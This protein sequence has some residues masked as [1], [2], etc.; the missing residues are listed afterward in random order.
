MESLSGLKVFEA[1]ATAGAFARA[2][3]DLDLSTSATSKSIARLES[4]L[5]VKLFR[6]TTRKVSLT[7][8]G[9]R[10]L[11]GIKPILRDL[12]A[13]KGEMAGTRDTP[14]G[15][16]TV[17][18]PAAFG[19]MALIPKLAPFQEGFPDVQLELRLE[20]RLVDLVSDNIDVAIRA[21]ALT[22]SATLIAR[23]LFDDQL[24]TCAAPAYLEREGLPRS[25]EDLDRHACLAFRNVG[26]GRVAPWFF[27]QEGSVDR[28]V[29]EGGVTSNDGEGVA[30]AAMA[31]LGIS[32]MPSYMA[33]AAIADGRLVEVL[34][35]LRPP[36]TQFHAL[37]LDRRLMP[38]RLRVFVDYLVDAFSRDA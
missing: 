34:E 19:R 17:S 33:S 10:L 11:E 12:D 32:Q 1:V 31:G 13:L 37:F 20:D 15:R 28:V 22:D 36:P 16:L 2:A 7:P 4:E 24:L 38:S 23:K 14:A 30:V 3:R 29:K 18:V 9:E 8:E 35:E 27:Q 6:R 26:T 21:G 25:I 5:G